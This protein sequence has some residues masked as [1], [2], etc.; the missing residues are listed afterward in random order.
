MGEARP[1]HQVGEIFRI[2]FRGADKARHAQFAE[3]AHGGAVE[4]IKRPVGGDVLQSTLAQQTERGEVG[5]L[6]T[7]KAAPHELLHART[8]SGERRLFRK[9]R[10]GQPRVGG[11]FGRRFIVCVERY[12]DFVPCVLW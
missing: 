10:Q 2:V 3:L 7:A 11:T 12:D 4:R 5:R 9:D 8:Q 6:P 1:A